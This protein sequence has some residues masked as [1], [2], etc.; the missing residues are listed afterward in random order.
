MEAF[1]RPKNLRDSLVHSSVSRRDIVGSG[2][3]NIPRCMTCTS[4]TS[5]TTFTTTITRKSYN[6]LHSLSCHSHNV[7]YL[8]TCNLCNKQYVGLTSQT[9]R[10][11]FNT[12]RFNINND[13]GD[14]VAKHFNLPGH[15]IRNA[16]ITPI[17][18]LLT[19]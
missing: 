2:P 9:L 17:D 18:Q 3:C 11:R 4:I 5:S 13:R 1:R 19:A 14:A 15:T 16:K 12:H 8:I 7:I 6:I 10:K